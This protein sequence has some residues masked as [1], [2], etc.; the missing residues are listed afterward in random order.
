MTEQPSGQGRSRRPASVT[1]LVLLVFILALAHLF[2]VIDVTRRWSLYRAMETALPV[3]AIAGLDGL[4]AAI[5]AALGGG[6]WA[7]RE[8]A[9][10]GTVVAVPAY[11]LL[12]VGQIVL[13]A[14]SPY[15]HDRLPFQLALAGV[16]SA[17]VLF[18]LTRPGIKQ[19]FGTFD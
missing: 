11:M 12:A 14:R 1:W 3:L 13:F 2:G 5:W 8:W 19:V 6:L 10:Q 17:I 7:C 15:A 9:R 4:W 16:I 18:W